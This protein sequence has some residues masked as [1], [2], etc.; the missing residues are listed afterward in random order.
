MDILPGLTPTHQEC[1]PNGVK[2]KQVGAGADRTRLILDAALHPTAPCPL[3]VAAVDIFIAILGAEAGNLALKVFA[4]GG[5]YLAG[6]IPLHLLAALGKGGVLEAF[7]RKGRFADLLADVPVHV[8]V[9]RA[10]IIG[11]A[12][13]GLDLARQ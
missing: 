9:C 4:T 3:C 7:Q 6:G 12:S 1:P 2:P 5:V 13:L 8:I 11:A 10:A